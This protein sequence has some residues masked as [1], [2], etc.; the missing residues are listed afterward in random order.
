MSPFFRLSSLNVLL[1]PFFFWFLISFCF[2][3]TPHL[4][5]LL[6]FTTLISISTFNLYFYLF[7]AS[8]ISQIHL[9]VLVIALLSPPF[10][11]HPFIPSSLTPLSPLPTGTR[12]SSLCSPYDIIQCRLQP[13]RAT[14]R[15]LVALDANPPD[16]KRDEATPS[17]PTAACSSSTAGRGAS[18]TP[19]LV[20]VTTQTPPP[21]WQI[22]DIVGSSLVHVL[23]LV[24]LFVAYSW[25]E[26]T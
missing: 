9:Y 8:I 3:Y 14:V 4:S 17:P 13:L 12:Q 21:A 20:S 18:G 23:C 22:W 26:L 1:H 2:L 11:L 6:P 10:F 24:L 25:S 19:L 7:S 5:S 15:A 16:G